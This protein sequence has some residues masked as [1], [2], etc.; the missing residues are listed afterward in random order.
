MAQ[1][2]FKAMPAYRQG[3][4]DD[5]DGNRY[6]VELSSLPQSRA[7]SYV[8]RGSFSNGDNPADEALL[9][10]RGPKHAE[11]SVKAVTQTSRSVR[12]R[13]KRHRFQGWRFGVTVSAWTAFAVLLLN[14]ILT[15]YAGVSYPHSGGLGLA[16][17]GKCST[18]NNWTTWLH[19]LINGLSSILLSASN[20][21]M[22]CLCSPTREEIDQAHGRGD[23]LDIGVPSVRNIW[24]MNWRRTVLWWLLAL[25]SIPIHLLY[26][27]AIFKSLAANQYYMLVVNE[28]FLQGNISGHWSGSPVSQKTTLVEA[29]AVQ[30]QFTE[31]DA[32]MNPTMVHNLTNTE[33]MQAYGSSFVSDYLSVLAIT[34]AQANY[35]VFH[36][37]AVY[38]GIDISD[39]SLPYYWICLDD[40][41]TYPFHVCDLGQALRTAD[42]WT[43][44]DQKI[45][46]CLAAVSDPHCQLQFS[47]QILASVIVMNACK[48]ICM[49]LTLRRRREEPLVTVGDA[50]S[51][52]LNRPDRLTKGRCLM[53]KVDVHRGPLRWRLRAAG[54]TSNTAPLPVT[55]HAPLQR[56]WFAAASAKRWLI[57]ICLCIAALITAGVLLGI[58]VQKL[59]RYTSYSEAFSMGFGS[60]D[61]RALIDAGLP[62]GGSGGLVSAVLLANLP[63][64]IVSFLYLTYNGLFTCMLLSHEY[65]KFGPTGRKRPLRVTT[66]YGQQRSSYSLQL[67]YRYSVPLIVASAT[68]HWLISQSIFLVRVSVYDYTGNYDGGDHSEVGFSC[69]PILLTILL[70]SAMMFVAVGS[71]FRKFASYIPVAGSCSVA[72]AAAAHRPKSDVGA[73]FLPVQW[74]EVN[75]EGTDEI[76]HCC[77]T[78]EEVHD[79][80]EGRMYAGSA[81][82]TGIDTPDR[83]SVQ[84]R[85]AS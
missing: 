28:D 4:Q 41:V 66:P 76:G 2:V 38:Y 27:S 5:F 42:G 80:I 40:L 36:M 13:V 53:A 69:L 62:K 43:I 39:S 64:A 23:W 71:G 11:S 85:N 24:R 61:A 83:G 25:S 6:E 14:L 65:S 73:A 63:Q 44:A 32:W 50:I 79:L 19:V 33:C 57:T 56:R 30:R 58:G 51:S 49:F 34:S 22:Q 59:S 67:P 8:S 12:I 31:H 18:V 26:N 15:I 55:Y 54:K 9:P 75:S 52:F 84:E 45:D 70:G 7:P 81:V 35:T 77:F 16:F 47:I 60:V 68:L 46:Y 1:F 3:L 10:E 21:T 82:T 20:Y 74:G 17:E 48:C 78:S 37:D 72:L 29:E